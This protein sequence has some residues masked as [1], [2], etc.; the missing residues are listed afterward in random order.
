MQKK[1]TSLPRR[2]PS[3]NQLVARDRVTSETVGGVQ[4]RRR[5]A[6][7]TTQA[8]ANRDPLGKREVDRETVADRFQGCARGSDGEVLLRRPDV[9]TGDFDRNSAPLAPF[10]PKR[11]RQTHEAQQGL[12]TVKAV[13]LPREHPQEEIDFGQGRQGDAGGRHV[14]PLRNRLNPPGVRVS[15]QRPSSVIGTSVVTWKAM[16]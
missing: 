14:G 9:G 1:G 2:A 15:D 12:D 6:R 4:S 3:L 13:L 10:R 11:V 5:V 8:G 16:A 7:A